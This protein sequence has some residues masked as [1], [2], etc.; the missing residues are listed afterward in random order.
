LKTRH[1]VNLIISVSFKFIQ[2]AQNLHLLE[3]L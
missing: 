2:Q 3:R 1:Q